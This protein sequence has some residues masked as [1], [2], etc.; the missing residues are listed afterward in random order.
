MLKGNSILYERERYDVDVETIGEGEREKEKGRETE[1]ERLIERKREEGQFYIP[2]KHL[3]IPPTS[4][5]TN[6]PLRQ[7]CRQLARQPK[8][9]EAIST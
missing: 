7:A 5:S 6:Q 2:S 9:A 8:N 3:S 1:V 4:Q